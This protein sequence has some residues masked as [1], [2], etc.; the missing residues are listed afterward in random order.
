[1]RNYVSVQT[2][3]SNEN[4]E[5]EITFE[6]QPPVWK[7]L[8]SA[9]ICRDI[10]Y[11]TRTYVRTQDGWVN[12]KDGVPVTNMVDKEILAGLFYMELSQGEY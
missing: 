8:V 1:M 5:Q 10:A 11:R 7:V 3:T 9:L 2:V 12:K 4:G 6:D